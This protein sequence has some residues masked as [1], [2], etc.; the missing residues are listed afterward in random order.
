MRSGS[1]AV[2]EHKHVV[3]LFPNGTSNDTDNDN[4]SKVLKEHQDWQLV[5]VIRWD[6]GKG[7]SYRLFFTRE[8]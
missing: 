7:I 8:L 5:S 2:F 1:N 6:S 4:M 3:V